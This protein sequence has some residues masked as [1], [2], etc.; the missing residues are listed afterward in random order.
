[1]IKL[2]DIL[3]EFPEIIDDITFDK[4]WDDD[5]FN[6][7]NTT[8][9]VNS[10]KPTEKY[11]EYDVYRFTNN[12][13]ITD[14]YVFP[15]KDKSAYYTFAT[16]GFIKKAD[17]IKFFHAWRLQSWTNRGLIVDLYLNK[18]LPE[19]KCIESDNRQTEYGKSL[20]KKLVLLCLKH[21][22]DYY[23]Y[24]KDIVSNKQT[25]ILSVEDFEKSYNIPTKMITNVGIKLK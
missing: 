5:V 4:R 15:S 17:S 14:F 11:N 10:S 23:I 24:Y 25:E 19:Y 7:T 3:L 20:W 22:K 21:P 8:K 6:V 9:M 13:K 1:M 12:N 18:Y 16:V 2:K